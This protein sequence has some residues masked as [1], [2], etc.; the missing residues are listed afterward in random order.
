MEN[1]ESD[2]SMFL[3][4]KS[5]MILNI[6]NINDIKELI[7]M[8]FTGDYSIDE[9]ISI[10]KKI[11]K[12]DRC[13]CLELINRCISIYSITKGDIYKNIL[14]KIINLHIDIN[15]KISCA[16]CLFSIN[17]NDGYN[18][19][20]KL[21]NLKSFNTLNCIV[22]IEILKILMEIID[23]YK[24][25]LKKILKICL[26][27]NIDIQYRYDIIQNIQKNN[28]I[29][30]KYVDA[31]YL[32]FLNNKNTY[33]RYK[34]YAS[35]YIFKHHNRFNN[36]EIK[37]I[38]Y[39]CHDICLD[40]MMDYN[41]RADCAD[42]LIRCSN[43]EE[44]KNIARD[45]II[46]LGVSKGGFKTIYNNRQNVHE[47]DIDN[48]CK[49]ILEKLAERDMSVRDGKIVNFD[50]VCKE[51][52]DEIKDEG[53]SKNGSESK[54]E[55]EKINIIKGSLLRINID[56]ALYLGQTIKTIFIKIWTHLCKHEHKDEL[57]KRL[58]EELV[59]SK[60]K[61][62]SGYVTRLL[63]VFSGYDNDLSIQI[64]YKHQIKSNVIAILNRKIK[65]IRDEEIKCELVDEFIIDGALS[66]KK[67]LSE[68]F[69]NNL[70]SIRDEM[71]NEYKDVIASKNMSEQEFEEYF[72]NTIS[73][74]ECGV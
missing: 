56:Q 20:K 16:D 31:L 63:N 8:F 13:V 15:T 14:I 23:N 74:F 12:I 51:L 6:D 37:N 46:M 43:N 3:S 22:K 7:D 54:D 66:E 49:K 38:E 47:D 9:R 41:I 52:L 72:R 69:R 53:E 21:T 65:N 58:V 18:Y 45:I 40:N 29:N 35:Q 25:T 10:L 62:G 28:N 70:M 59:D 64:S 71:L 68:F 19:Y 34:I 61:C 55:G 42:M 67:R 50:D 57:K 1:E 30:I 48:S 39:I 32:N 5:S 33:T 2:I 26:D 44:I 60:G 24:H 27:K 4:D 11:N 36:E 17:K 73:E